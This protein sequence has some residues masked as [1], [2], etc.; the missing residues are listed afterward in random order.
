VVTIVD[1]SPWRS[2]I[3]A[4]KPGAQKK[5]PPLRQ[6]VEFGMPNDSLTKTLWLKAKAG[7]EASF[8]RLFGLH[9]DRLHVFVKA[10]LGAALREK[11]EAEDVLQDAYVSALKS[12]EQFEY[13][14]EGAFLR[15]MCRIIDH[16]LRD[17]NDY[18]TA[19]K[20]QAIPL[21]RKAPT[22]PSTALHRVE[23]RQ[24]VESALLQLSEEHRQV[25]LLRYFEGLSTEEAGVRMNRTAGAIRNLCA[26]ALVELGKHLGVD[27]E[28]RS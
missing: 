23:A 21:A 6:P 2:T 18:F 16:R 1:T 13:A 14:D 4:N 8:A 20:R 17:A 7:D 5:P 12:F 19:D 10:K 28:S 27:K 11:I 9:A 24:K 15:W 26:R 22:G 3:D 25:I